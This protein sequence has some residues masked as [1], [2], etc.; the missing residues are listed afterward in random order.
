MKK[1]KLILIVAFALV[2]VTIALSWGAVGE[3][4]GFLKHV[5]KER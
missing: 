1:L 5:Q 3:A 4:G 2:G